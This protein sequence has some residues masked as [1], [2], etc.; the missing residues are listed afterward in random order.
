MKFIFLKCIVLFIKGGQGGDLVDNNTKYS[1]R[2]HLP[3]GEKQLERP[4]LDAMMEAAMQHPLTAIVAGAGYG[5]TRAAANFLASRDAKVLW[6]SLTDIDNFPLRFWQGF[7]A[8]AERLNH[9]L[10]PALLHLGFPDSDVGFE[11]FIDLLSPDLS[12][13]EPLTIVLDDFHLISDQSVQT[14]VENLAKERVDGLRVFLLSR[15][16]PAFSATNLAGM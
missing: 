13:N 16:M 3:Y 14:F 10:A 6:L 12:L 15:E 7:C 4:R 5:K 2:S 9:E 8:A 1:G 11:R